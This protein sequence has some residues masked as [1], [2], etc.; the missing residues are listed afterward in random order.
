MRLREGDA[1]AVTPFNHGA[2]DPLA[3]DPT[4]SFRVAYEDE[5]MLVI[6]K[7]AGVVVH[8]AAGHQ[9][10][11]LVNGLLAR[12]PDLRA[13]AEDGA[14]PGIVHRLDKDT[15]GLMVVGRTVGATAHLQRQM[16]ARSTEKR[17]LAL[18]LGN[19]GETEGLVDA[20]IAR[21]P[22]RR[23]RMAVVAGGR[24]S[25]TAFTVRERFGDWTLVEAQLLTGRTHQLR[26]HFASIGHPIAGD[27][28]YGPRAG[29]AP[30]GVTR[31]FLHS[32]LLR[33]RSPHDGIERTWS[34]EL[35][36]DLAAPLE[37]LRRRGRRGG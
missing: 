20:P 33:A 19:V 10:D 25:Q 6:D 4:I 12:Y 21:N 34:A 28:T 29:R 3:A 24:T 13:A 17:Y 2:A 15:S 32:W 31:Q 16:Q 14:R 11:T 8:P 23:D 36:P 1:I 37:A 18:I 35:P 27:A 30:I 22:R 7:P 5:A 26:V 9:A